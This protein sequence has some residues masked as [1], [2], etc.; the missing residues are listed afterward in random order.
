MQQLDWKGHF[1]QMTAPDTIY[2]P[3]LNE[4][5]DVWR[6]VSA[7]WQDDG[8]YVIT[9]TIPDDE[10]WMFQPGSRVRCVLKKLS[11]GWCL[12]AVEPARAHKKISGRYL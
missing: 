2:M 12:V 3:L 7:F 8:S 5:T 10:E 6:P 11:A 9:G 4:G 1:N